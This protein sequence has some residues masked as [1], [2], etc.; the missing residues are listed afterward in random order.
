MPTL[1]AQYLDDLARVRLEAAALSP[2]VVY[3]IERSTDGGVTW[4]TVRGATNITAGGVTVVYDYE[5]A[6]NVENQYRLTQ[7]LVSDTFERTTGPNALVLTGDSGSYASTPD[8]AALDITGNIDISAIIRFPD[9]ST[10]ATPTITGKYVSAGSQRSYWFRVGASGNL[11]AVFS[12][13]GANTT[14]ITSTTTLYAE[15]V[16]DN[17]IIAVR[18]TRVAATGAVVFYLGSEPVLDPSSWDQVGTG[19]TG[20]SG[21]LFDSTSP[22]E[23][24]TV[25][26]GVGDRATGRII[27]TRVRNGIAGTIVASPHFGDEPTG[28]T[29]FADSTGKTWTVHGTAT[30]EGPEQAW[31]DADT[32]QTWDPYASN[33]EGVWWV[34][35]GAAHFTG[36]TDPGFDNGRFID[37]VFTDAE[38]QYDIILTEG[39]SQSRLSVRGTSANAFTGYQIIITRNTVGS[40]AGLIGLAV[41]IPSEGPSQEIILGPWQLGQR[42]RVKTRVVGTVIETKAWNT[43]NPEPSTWQ[44]VRTSTQFAS[45]V[46]GFNLN[47][48][49]SAG[50]NAIVDNFFIHQVPPLA[51]A[52]ADVTP[53]QS[54]VWLKSIAFPSLNQPLGCIATTPRTRRSRVGLFDVR[55]RHAILGIA[56]VGSTETFTVVFNTTSVEQNVA[57]TGL[58]TFG[59]PLLLQSPPD[60]DPS[61]C[62]PIAAYPSGWFMPGDNV[63]ARALPG[64]RLWEWQVPL[65]RVAPPSAQAITPAHMTWSVLWQ[66]VNTWVELWDEWATWAELWDAT[67]TPTAMYEA[68]SGGE[69]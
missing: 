34:D 28:T 8:T 18:V 2:E 69:G 24:G 68:L 13:T 49:P 47:V 36:I 56:D 66:M 26:L 10:G 45:G 7:P 12:T 14:T 63:Q 33:G 29:S 25:N 54:E 27:A 65:T 53:M 20:T 11:Q 23:V 57:V 37:Q 67:I 64:E 5:Y 48:N 22:L 44:V 4:T 59:P 43:A 21:N 55:G 15:G 31:G 35:D 41:F 3:S 6:P 1:T 62:G 61:G 19:V 58:L 30:I 16:A 42:W 40:D 38:I 32:G 60:A 51:V 50:G 9:Y 46:I 17:D 52:T 39:F